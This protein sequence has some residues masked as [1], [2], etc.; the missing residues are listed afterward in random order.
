MTAGLP[1]AAPPRPRQ[2][3]WDNL[4]FVAITLV[5]VGHVAEQRMDSDT[6]AALVVVLYAF[7]MPLFAFVCGRF[8][9]AGPLTR[10]TARKTTSQLVVPYLVFSLAW[11]ALRRVVEGD[12][13]LDLA[14]PYW[15]LWFLV[16]LAVWRAALPYLAELRHPLL[17]SVLVSVGAGYV[18]S[19]G[20]VFDSGRIFAM[21]PFFVLGWVSKQQAWGEGGGR[22]G[23]DALASLTSAPARVLA[24]AVLV[25]AL[26]VGV[27]QVDTVRALDLQEWAR[28]SLPYTA[29]GEAQW[30]SGGVRLVQLLLAVLL[31]GA[32]MAL[33]PRGR[34]VLTGWGGAT[35]Y[36][37]LLH[38]VPIYLLRELTD[39]FEWFDSLPRLTLLVALAVAWTCVL[40]TRAVRRFSRPV[41]EPRLSW[42][43][44]DAPD[45]AA[46]VPAPDP[47]PAT[48]PGHR[49]DRD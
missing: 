27:L 46:R 1:S 42:L 33:V 48:G 47:T 28:M 49:V 5:V 3:Y 2:A 9:T 14:K 45:E 22:F 40:S 8:A 12:V 20:A 16:A 37:Y 31:G 24:A 34:S 17:V 38:L 10:A 6:M 41:V 32:L 4:R 15:H 43:F 7:H 29:T 35:M 25:A 19:A 26:V 23:R 36:V 18:P 44:R 39:A 21:L 13:G 30:W 11:F